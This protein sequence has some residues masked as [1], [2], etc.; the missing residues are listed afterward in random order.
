M[1]S[2]LYQGGTLSAQ[3][4]ASAKALEAAK[5]TVSSK[6]RDI[7][8]QQRSYFQ[9]VTGLQNNISLLSERVKTITETRALYREQYLSL[10]TRSVLDL[11][12]AEQEISLAEQDLIN[13]RCDLWAASMNY[14]VL[15]SMAR[16]IL[17]FNN[18]MIQGWRL[19]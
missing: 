10:G 11:L 13:S 18:R 5:A 15:A 14:L 17:N 2:T 6:K 3:E 12:N 8:D 7:I 19:S 4:N 1:N 16:D 9:S